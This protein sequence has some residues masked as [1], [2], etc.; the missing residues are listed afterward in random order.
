LLI[1]ALLGR[2]TPVGLF[3]GLLFALAPSVVL[4]A[5]HG[6]G[7]RRLA[8]PLAPFLAGGAVVALFAGEHILHAYLGVLK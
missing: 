4:I 7:A 3:L 2:T 6:R 1:G 8:I 5:R